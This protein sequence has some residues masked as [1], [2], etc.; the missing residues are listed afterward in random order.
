MTTGRAPSQRSLGCLVTSALFM[1]APIPGLVLSQSLAPSSG[2]A[3][4]VSFVMFPLAFVLGAH[5][6]LGFV[7]LAALWRLVGK[8]VRWLARRPPRP[9][10]RPPT[11]A[12]PQVP[13]GS[14]VFVPVSV[15]LSGLAGVC[16]GFLSPAGFILTV[17]A[18]VFLGMLYGV[19]V[20]LLARAGY[21]DVDAILDGGGP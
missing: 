11:P 16:V 5:L 4:L 15:G 7:L 14:F 9:D 2:V 6:W 8:F 19:A 10:D 3:G 12:G 1:G 18:Y 17:G 21:V 13:P 20:W